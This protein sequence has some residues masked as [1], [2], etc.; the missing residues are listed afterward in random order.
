MDARLEPVAGILGLNSALFRRALK[1]MD[2]ESAERRPNEHTNS[3]AF[4]ACHALD[5]RFYLMRMC[6]H[7]M[8][9]PWREL[10]DAAHDV[11]DMKEVPPVYELLTVWEEV[12]EATLEHLQE[13][14]DS[15]LDADSSERFPT[16][17]GSLLGGIAFLAFHEAYHVGQMGLLRKYL[18]YGPVV[19]R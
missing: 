18:G 7:D 14:S 12:H 17:D 4:V 2:Q 16:E 15:E 8:T 19:E 13:M 1:G 11:S 9:N 5:A 10:F 3:L 6:G